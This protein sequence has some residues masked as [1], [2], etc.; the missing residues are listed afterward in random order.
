MKN[1][2]RHYSSEH[3]WNPSNHCVPVLGTITIPDSSDHAI[4]VMRWMQSVLSV[5]ISGVL[6]VIVCRSMISQGLQ[7]MYR[8]GVAHR[9]LVSTYNLHCSMNNIMMDVTVM[10]PG[11]Y[12]P[13]NPEKKYDW[14]GRAR[15]HSRTRFPPRYLLIDFGF[16]NHDSSSVSPL[17]E[18]IHPVPGGKIPGVEGIDP[19]SAD[20]FLLGATIRVHILD[21]SIYSN[22]C[23]PLQIIYRTQDDPSKQPKID[24]VVARFTAIL[25]ILPSS[26]LRARF[27]SNKQVRLLNGRLL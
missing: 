24:E 8:N 13:A 4:L 6:V 17:K 5:R 26:K 27:V 21:D 3:S 11:G 19:F 2:S 25:D 16:R 12:L 20:V 18:T 22:S 7:Y 1:A 10:Y 9:Y 23:V 14:S 15:H